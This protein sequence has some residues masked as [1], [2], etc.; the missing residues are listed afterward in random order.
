MRAREISN[1]RSICLSR[2]SPGPFRDQERTEYFASGREALR[3]LIDSVLPTGKMTVLLPD[4]VPEG[5]I[6]PFRTAAW[7]VLLYPID[8]NLDPLWQRL[9]A[10]LKARKPAIAVLIH[11]FG[12]AKDA[13]RFRAL[14]NASGA[15][16]IE[17]LAHVLPGEG[18]EAGREG[19]YVLY[20]P[21]KTIGSPDG[22]IL[23]RRHG[24]GMAF[25]KRKG[26]RAHTTY[27]VQQL[28]LLCVATLGRRFTAG[29]WLRL[30]R[31]LS[32]RFLN[33][34][35]TLSSYSHEPHQMSDI[36][37]FLLRHADW[38]GWARRRLDHASAYDRGL[39]G[40]IFKRVP[41]SFFPNGGPFGFPVMV[42]D[43]DDLQE[44]LAAR[45]I[46]GLTLD[47]RW[48]FIPQEE[49]Q[50]HPGALAVLRK[51]FLF[52][53]DQHLADGQIQTVI[54]AANDWAALRNRSQIAAPVAAVA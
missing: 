19:D 10:L 16:M 35:E 20:S 28:L 4:Y 42:D 22:G 5:V 3:S 12:L 37:R 11:Y 44:H 13:G 9:E 38:D 1:D 48:D 39:D 49:R 18:C 14:C 8:E 31:R 6:R 45:G 29:R 50:E 47:G 41:G 43:R 21:T 7:E 36:G 30:L 15:L 25:P 53:T 26:S 27:V 34:Y 51:H 54:A 46:R 40:K 32:G 33:S 24:A 52:P 2:R 23:V 17:D